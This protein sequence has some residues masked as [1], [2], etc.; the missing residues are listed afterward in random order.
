MTDRDFERLLYFDDQDLLTILRGV[1]N[2]QLLSALSGTDCVSIR[3]RICEVLSFNGARLLMAD[4]ERDGKER[5][6]DRPE[7]RIT[8][9]ELIEDMT[10]RGL[11]RPQMLPHQVRR[12]S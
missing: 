5:L 4:L 12:A 10:E 2:T 1:S 3:L 7:A 6:P 8:I 11:I 9:L